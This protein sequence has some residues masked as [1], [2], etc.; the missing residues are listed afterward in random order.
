MARWGSCDYRKL[1]RLQQR[2]EQLQEKDLDAFCRIT[3]NELDSR[4]L[5]RVKLRTPVDS[6]ELRRRWDIGEIRKNGD[7]Y[8]IEIINPME[9]SSYV[10]F[11]H[12]TRDHRGWVK[13]RFMLT[14]SEQ[15][16]KA[17]APELIQRKL[18]KFLKEELGW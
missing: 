14:I 15:E 6:G 11:G 10:E 16:L 18:Y 8:E 1:R 2:L 3:S 12:R 4:L 9:Y 7:R 17:Q 13:G 5:R